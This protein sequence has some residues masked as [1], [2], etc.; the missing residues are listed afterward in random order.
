MAGIVPL[1]MVYP[2]V[3]VSSAAPAY[4]TAPAA[5]CTPQDHGAIGDGKTLDTAA[6]NTAIEA[7]AEVVFPRAEYLT[8][9]IQLRNNTRLV[10]AKGATVLAAPEGN[11]DLDQAPPPPVCTEPGAPYAPYCQDYGHSVW[12]DALISGIGV[13]NV[14]I[15]GSGV[16]DGN[17]NLR[18]SCSEAGARARPGCKLLAL[19]TVH[20]VE[21]AGVTFKRGGWFTMLLT[22]V[23][24]VHLHD[25]E[26][27]A[28]RDGIDLMG[29]RHVLAERLWIHGGGDDAFKL[30]SDW[31]LGRRLDSYNITLRNSVLSSGTCLS[32]Y[33][34]VYPLVSCVRGPGWLSRVSMHPIRI[35]DQRKLQRHSFYKHHLHQCW[36]G[37]DWHHQHGWCKHLCAHFHEYFPPWHHGAYPH[38]RGGASVG[39][40]A[41][42][43]PRWL[44]HQH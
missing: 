44:H 28:G 30:G 7:C 11:Y 1:L 41:T 42:T 8:G 4:Y 27:E 10:L 37:W 40:A 9:T 43:L 22:N 34:K 39:E 25:F 3:S 12:R 2:L 15:I 20:G 5:S 24:D 21:I 31:S 19:Q 29:M 33:P 26:I 14:S 36:Q 32:L 17:G 18:H 6:I 38:V 23:W 16:F 13:A 35:R